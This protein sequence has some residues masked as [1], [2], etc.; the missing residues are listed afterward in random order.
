MAAQTM[1]NFP[2]FANIEICKTKFKNARM[3]I[4]INDDLGKEQFR[5][6]FS[7]EIYKYGLACPRSILEKHKNHYSS[8]NASWEN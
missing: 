8:E 3:A 2:I 5:Q 6:Y 7:H 1:M 4:Y